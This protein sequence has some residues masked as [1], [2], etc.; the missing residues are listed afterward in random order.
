MGEHLSSRQA[1]RV[2]F[3]LGSTRGTDVGERLSACALVMD[4]YAA[5]KHSAVRKWLAG[6]ARFKVHCTLPPTPCG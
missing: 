5:H 2:R 4:N 3:A 1:G 6:H